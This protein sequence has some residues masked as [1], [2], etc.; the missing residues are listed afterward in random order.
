MNFLPFY[1]SNCGEKSKQ[2]ILIRCDVFKGR[3]FVFDS[4]RKE[5]CNFCK[6][7]FLDLPLHTMFWLKKIKGFK[8]CT[9]WKLSKYGVIS[10]P[11]FPAFVLNTERY[12][13]LRIQ[14]ELL[15]LFTHCWLT[16]FI[17]LI[18]FYPWKYQKTRG[19]QVV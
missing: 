14:S 10:S 7:S 15:T 11:Y 13:S 18:S 17:P 6:K 3:L 4:L 19:F 5:F 9:A 2:N 12:V 16:H 8:S 1:F